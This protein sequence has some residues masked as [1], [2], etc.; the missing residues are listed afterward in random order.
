MEMKNLIIEPTHPLT[1]QINGTRNET[2]QHSVLN[3]YTFSSLYLILTSGLGDF[4]FF[5][6]LR[7]YHL[8]WL[9]LA[10][11][12]IFFFAGCTCPWPTFCFEPESP[13]VNLANSPSVFSVTAVLP[14]LRGRRN[15][16]HLSP[17]VSGS[18]PPKEYATRADE[19]APMCGW[20]R[21]SL[22]NVSN[23]LK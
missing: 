9:T 10:F 23:R 5:L 11:F 18:S 7:R 14:H 15:H 20:S 16:Q 22:I 4:I 1:P 8:S 6:A 3:V 12:D 21:E 2:K 17:L 19:R 13:T